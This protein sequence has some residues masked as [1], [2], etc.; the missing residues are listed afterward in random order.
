VLRLAILVRQSIPIQHFPNAPS[1]SDPD[2]RVERIDFSYMHDPVSVICVYAPNEGR[3]D[4]FESLYPF[5][6][7]GRTVLMGGDFI[8]ILLLLAPP[9]IL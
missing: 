7:L 5:I 8:C 1:S 4:F 9:L 6:P 2:C 3:S